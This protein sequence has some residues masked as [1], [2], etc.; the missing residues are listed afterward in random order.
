M[1]EHKDQSE[2]LDRQDLLVS[3][4]SKDQLG[5]EVHKEALER[6]VLW[7]LLVQREIQGGAVR[8][9]MQDQPDQLAYPEETVWPEA[10]ERKETEDQVVSLDQ[11]EY[12]G[13][14]D[15][16]ARQV[17]KDQR[18]QRVT[19]DPQ[20][21]PAHQEPRAKK[22]LRVLPGQLDQLEHLVQKVRLDRKVQLVIKV[23]LEMP[24]RQETLE[25]PAALEPQEAPVQ[26]VQRVLQVL[27]D[28]V[29]RL[30]KQVR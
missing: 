19:Q 12:P 21:L 13:H 6:Q 8:L 24:D 4:D 16:L 17:P 14:R 15:Q 3:L 2:V 7:D 20:E 26:S 22:D 27:Q 18:A 25:L 9:E 29:V 30:D 5:K 28:Q 11:R 1:Q 10:L 23:Q